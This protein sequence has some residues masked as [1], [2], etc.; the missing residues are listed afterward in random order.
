MPSWGYRAPV[1]RR[2]Y[3]WGA[4]DRKSPLT[5]QSERLTPDRHHVVCDSLVRDHVPRT[6]RLRRRLAK[7][8][9]RLV[10][11]AERILALWQ[12]IETRS[13]SVQGDAMFEQLMM[14]IGICQLL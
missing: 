4:G 3:R 13:G 1:K 8:P 10:R 14:S 5:A 7:L 2:T 12:R 9:F 6:T 11:R